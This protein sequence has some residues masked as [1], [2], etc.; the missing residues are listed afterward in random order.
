MPHRCSSSPCSSTDV[1]CRPPA[2]P[3]GTRSGRDARRRDSAREPSSPSSSETTPRP[4]SRSRTSFRSAKA[5]T[6]IYITAGLPNEEP[7][8][9]DRTQLFR[10][11]LAPV[12]VVLPDNAWHMGLLFGRPGRR[13]GR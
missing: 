5:P 2:L 10:P 1:R 12:G 8:T 11:G 3:A 13:R 4:R 6:A 7:H 9:L